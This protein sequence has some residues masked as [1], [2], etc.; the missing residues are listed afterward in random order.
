MPGQLEQ[1]AAS[2]SSACLEQVWGCMRV[3]PLLELLVGIDHHAAA[4]SRHREQLYIIAAVAAHHHAILGGIP[5]LLDL[6][7]TA[8][9]VR[10]DRQ[11]V[12]VRLF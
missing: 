12:K 8:L 1:R 11:S 4:H 7:N 5:C 9:W 6:H 10:C 2:R 3:T